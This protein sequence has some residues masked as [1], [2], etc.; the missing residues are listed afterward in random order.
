LILVVP[1]V[2]NHA[3]H[4]SNKVVVILMG[5][6][7]SGKTLIGRALAAELG[8]RFVDAD[9]FHAPSSV[10]KMT[11]GVP[12]DDADRAPWLAALHTVIARAIDRRES[13]V[14]ACSALKA[15]YREA[16]RG[17]LRPVRFVHLA[18]DEDTLRK[19]LE[20]RRDHFA[21]ASLLRSQLA[22]LEPPDDAV[23][24]DATK[25]P[26]RLLAA[27]RTELGI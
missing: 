15:R 23:T 17:D 21:G 26:E 4:A 5:V 27:I 1:P 22:A 16:L 10:N 8:W 11:A 13:L 3:V 18:A 2:V 25:P 12:L 19:R 20:T 14:V 24:L 7:G 6:A 9:D